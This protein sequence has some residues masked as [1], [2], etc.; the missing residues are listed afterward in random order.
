MSS[1][2]S[3]LDFGDII[4]TM[5]FIK[6]PQKIIE[7][8]VLEGYSLDK[9]IESSSKNC[10]INA[11][12]IFD[13]FN[14]K[15]SDYS[16]IKKYS[17]IDRVNVERGDFYKLHSSIP[18]KSIDILHVDIANNGDVYEFV[19]ENYLT[20]MADNGIIILE[21]GSEERDSV[22]WMKKYN[23]PL[24]QPVIR[25]YSKDYDIHIVGNF[26]SMTIVRL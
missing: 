4:N 12:D 21:G 8:G 9:F 14:G 13:D 5:T 7:F 26:P 22:Y 25:K 3:K 2:E 16:I 11:Y 6:N 1:Y 10:I 17:D 24:I 20:K 18:D 23:K 15:H 19:F